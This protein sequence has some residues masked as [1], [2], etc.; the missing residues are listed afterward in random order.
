MSDRVTN[1]EIEDV[2][3]S[4]RRLVSEAA[5]VTTPVSAPVVDT[6]P[7][8]GRLLLTEAYRVPAPDDADV[9]HAIRLPP[10]EGE[11]QTDILP[12]PADI[13]ADSAIVLDLPFAFRSRTPT[14]AV[15]DYSSHFPAEDA[16][17]DDTAGHVADRGDDDLPDGI[18]WRNIDP[19]QRLSDTVAGLEAATDT[20][21]DV[22]EPDGSEN[23]P[24]MDWDAASQQAD[25]G[26]IPVFRSRKPPPLRLSP[27]LA[28]PPEP[29][30]PEPS[31][32]EPATHVESMA[33][34]ASVLPFQSARQRKGGDAGQGDLADQ[35]RALDIQDRETGDDA[36]DAALMAALR[37]ANGLNEALLRDM[38]LEIVRQELQGALGERITRN[39]RKLVRREIYRVLN[40]ADQD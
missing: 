10:S 23:T 19:G 40:E 16:V 7:P 24:V 38:V 18:D 33:P 27:E 1:V 28:V 8:V 5:P 37:D 11:E 39:V 21:P 32:P 36:S 17:Q 9:D 15:A 30:T 31:T 3:S 22:W 4:I 6:P 26:P 2:L 25:E 34:A 35:I 13:L 20:A 29:A 14:P 12:S